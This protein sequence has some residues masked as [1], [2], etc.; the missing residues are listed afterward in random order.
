[1]AIQKKI[2]LVGGAVRDKLMGVP[3]TD[4]DYV[5]VGFSEDEFSHLTKVGKGFPVFLQHDGSELA[6]A[7]TEKKTSS[8]Y[9]GFSTSINNVTLQEDLARRDLTIN[10]IAYDEES[11][12]Y[13]DPY[14][15]IKDI[16]NKVLRHTSKAFVED[17]LRV[18]RVARFY[19]K[20]GK[21]WSIADTTKEL[22]S[23][24]ENELQY[25]QKDRVYKEIKKASKYKFFYLFFKTLFR[26]NVI[27]SIFPTIALLSKEKIRLKLSMELLGALWDKPI[28]F[29]LC[30][31]YYYILPLQQNGNLQI[32][33]KVPK[34][35]SWYI[36]FL[37][38]Q[39]KK[40]NEIDSLD[41]IQIVEFFS[42]FK[43]DEKLLEDLLYLNNLIVSIEKEFKFIT[44]KQFNTN[45]IRCIF[46][47]ISSY[48][49]K[50]WI[51]SLSTKPSN[52]KISSHIQ[53]YNLQVISRYKQ[54][55][56]K[57]FIL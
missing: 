37:L 8:G 2:Y 48:S 15:G 6:L 32:D 40:L 55:Y 36:H 47:D 14:N 54:L 39:H 21:D 1:M 49:P 24:M 42:H 9:N 25:L 29:K 17:P 20:F 41:E 31:I 35:T 19:A 44:T 4:K 18:L 50:V 51:D 7:R 53:N 52:Q 26:L 16:K 3:I 45:V 43:R 10:S 28:G 13:I 34:R 23:S 38:S 5:A 30:A 22:I 57:P 11:K 33:I 12:N 27:G 46:N 56:K